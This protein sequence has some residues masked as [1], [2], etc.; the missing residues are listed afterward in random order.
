MTPGTAG[1]TP[2][3]KHSMTA[4]TKTC[5]TCGRT[6]SLTE[7]HRDGGLQRRADCRDCANAARRT[8]GTPARKDR[9]VLGCGTPA[10]GH[11]HYRRGE[12]PCPPCARALADKQAERDRA[13]RAREKAAKDLQPAAA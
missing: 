12:K 3:K 7:Y 2:R 4:K 10:A 8:P 5:K 13:R 1:P 9:P 11:R 6:L